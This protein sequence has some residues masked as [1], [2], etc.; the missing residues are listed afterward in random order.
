MSEDAEKAADQL[1]GARDVLVC[2]AGR[3]AAA[4]LKCLTGEPFRCAV[5]SCVVPDTGRAPAEIEGIPVTPISEYAGCRDALVVVATIDES[6]GRFE[7]ALR[8]SGFRN[9]MTLS[10]NSA[11]WEAVRSRY[12]EQVFGR[13]GRRY[14]RLKDGLRAA[15]FTRAAAQ[16][17]PE[18]AV[19]EAV[20]H[21]D[22]KLSAPPQKQAWVIPIQA[23]A[24]LTEEALAAVTDNRGE[25]ISEKNGTYCEL[26]ALYWIWKHSGSDYVGLCHYRRHFELDGPA[27]SLLPRTGIDVVLPTPILNFPS[28]KAVYCRDH[29]REDWGILMQALKEQAPD[30]YAQAARVFSDV[31]YYPYNMLLAKRSC[32]SDYCA[33]L[34]PILAL[35]E[36]RCSP[37]SDA[38]QNR[39]IG[40]MAERLTSLYFL[41]RSD[42]LH[43]AHAPKIFY[44]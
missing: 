27:L 3:A 9:T 19:Y 42:R 16:R 13:Q 36:S 40:F 8:Q 17:E 20:C 35:V 25:N 11:L 34:F 24:A 10:P 12:L 6:V 32:F 18:T 30:D 29:V 38:Y 39:Y 43:I 21:T 1:C 4:V 23:G 5:R 31:Y 28:V 14:L 7:K 26:T 37:K 22:R 44:S 33:W 41:A 2:G 15:R